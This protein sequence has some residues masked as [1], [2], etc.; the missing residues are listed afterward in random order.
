[1]HKKPDSSCEVKHKSLCL[2]VLFI[3]FIIAIIII[4]FYYLFFISSLNQAAFKT[5]IV[6]LHKQNTFGLVFFFLFVSFF[7]FVFV[8]MNIPQRLSC[9]PVSISC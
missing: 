4:F 7:I 5:S 1:M 3:I 2:L 9:S 8:I 6:Q